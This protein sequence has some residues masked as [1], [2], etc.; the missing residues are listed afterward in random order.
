MRNNILIAII[1]CLAPILLFAQEL[2]T[3][4][5]HKGIIT[6]KN[7][8]KIFPENR[9]NN[10]LYA[11]N[12]QILLQLEG[13]SIIDAL[14]YNNGLFLVSR[15]EKNNTQLEYQTNQDD[16]NIEILGLK[17]ALLA[18]GDTRQLLR[19]DSSLSEIY[20]IDIPFRSASGFVYNQKDTLA[21][22]RVTNY[23]PSEEAGQSDIYVFG[24][25]ILK[26]DS[27]KIINLPK[28]FRNS[29][30]SLDLR[31]TSLKQLVIVTDNSSEEELIIP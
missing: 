10:A 18:S 22:Y 3:D 6:L 12:N 23:Q 25:S 1:L 19:Y 24:I 5:Q 2:R 15:D 20:L 26:D 4:R 16:S 13:K 27:N 31:W 28:R 9:I 7:G 14:E 8:Y 30:P 29:K 21:F 17:Y 11:D